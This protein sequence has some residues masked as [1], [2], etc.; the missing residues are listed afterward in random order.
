MIFNSGS[1]GQLIKTII[2][3]FLWLLQLHKNGKAD[4]LIKDLYVENSQLLKALEITEQR[5]KIAE[6]KNYLLEEKIS[7]LNKIV[8]D[9]NPSPLSSLPYHYKCS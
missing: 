1:S 4:V 8:R 3:F 9:L 7:S 2:I 6:K 5:Q